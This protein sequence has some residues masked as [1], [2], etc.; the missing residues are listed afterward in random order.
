MLTTSG[1][2]VD[3]Q[4]VVWDEG[5]WWLNDIPWKELNIYP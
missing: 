2:L 5:R 4:N 1:K 3:P